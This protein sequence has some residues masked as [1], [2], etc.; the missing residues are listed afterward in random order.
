MRK[1]TKVVAVASAA[2][3]LA[4]G[5]SMTSFA[6]TGWVEEDGT[7]YFYDN[8]GNRVEDAWKKS[9]EN[10]YWLDG[11]EGGAMAIEKIVEDDDDIY[12]VDANGVM[13][14]NTWVK[15]VNE[16]QD[17]DEDPAEYHYY[18]MQS[19]GKAYKASDN[20]NIRFRTIDGKRYA[21]DEDGKMLYGWV[22]EQGERQSDDDGWETAI[23]YLGNWDEGDMK[24][25]W[26][27]IYVYDGDEDDDMEHWFNFKSNGKKRFND[28]TKN[29]DLFKEEKINGKRYGFDN[30]G[31]MTYEWALATEG[32]KGASWAS[33]SSWRYFNNVE[34]GARVTK[35]WFKVVAPSEDNDNVFKTGYG[36]RTF[37]EDDA[38]DENERWYYANGDGI[39]E[40]GKIKKIKGKYYGFRPDGDKKAAAMLSGLVLMEVN[41]D[42][43][44]IIKVLDDGVDSDELNDL[45]D[46]DTSSEIVQSINKSDGEGII[47]LYY[48]GDEETDGAMK[49][50]ATTVILDGES[51][52]FLFNKTGGAESKG[53]GLT[54]VDD[55]KY[56]YSYGCRIKASSDDKYQVV[57]V[58]A[59]AGSSDAHSKS[60]VV[61]KVSSATLKQIA[62]NYY[63]TNSKEEQVNFV[64]HSLMLEYLGWETSAGE[65]SYEDLGTKLYL[66]NTSGN[67]QKS[68]VA[69]KDGD[70]WYFYVKDREVQLYTNNKDLK[71]ESIKDWEVLSKL[72][73]AD[74]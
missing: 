39:L 46:W 63:Y 44:D 43:G 55:N 74:N 23:Y 19:N 48:F 50:G 59:L 1:Q 69:A 65:I 56:I 62:S 9:G 2:A 21:F 3:L 49:T 53:R 8:D 13:V 60:V 12:Y 30:R 47:S 64:N 5:A 57:A 17:E 22:N 4:I 18:Y 32:E 51:Y 52:N 70:E 68:K 42:N 38:D 14:R 66:V 72:E 28:S 20:S 26:Q 11:E 27:K 31:V 35:G 58:T 24:I 34:D 73:I 61:D 10:W 71:N 16:E 41:P 15:V 67:I 37:A 36:D 33:T 6:A 40:A 54:G 7:W 45:L 29:N 25:G